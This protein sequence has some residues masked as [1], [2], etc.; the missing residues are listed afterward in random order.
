MITSRALARLPALLRLTAPFFGPKTRAIFH[1]GREF[2]EE[3]SET[4]AEWDFDMLVS[5][6]DT[7]SDGVLLEIS[8]LRSTAG[9]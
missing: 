8:N 7:S 9:H 2:S 3:L 4:R 5:A 6:S 1:K